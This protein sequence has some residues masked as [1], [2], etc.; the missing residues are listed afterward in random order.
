[1]FAPKIGG[2][3]TKRRAE[4]L[5]AAQ[6]DIPREHAMLKFKDEDAEAVMAKALQGRSDSEKE[7][8]LFPEPIA[9]AAPQENPF[10]SNDK[11]RR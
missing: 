3:I 9:I 1:M 8:P 5:P 6:T 2:R 7:E 10:G 11:G 4:S